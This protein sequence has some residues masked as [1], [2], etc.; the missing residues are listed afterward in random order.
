MRNPSITKDIQSD[1]TLSDLE[2]VHL[3]D[4][5]TTVSQLQAQTP[6]IIWLPNT[7]IS[8]GGL[9]DQF[10]SQSLNFSFDCEFSNP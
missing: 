1:N 10:W 9:L 6:F 7:L 5:W 8:L 4:L 3:V 2:K